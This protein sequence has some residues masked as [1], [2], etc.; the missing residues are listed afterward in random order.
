[1]SN[2]RF[3]SY[4][5]RE[6]NL[7]ALVKDDAET[8]YA[9]ELVR[10]YAAQEASVTVSVSEVELRGDDGLVSVDSNVSG[11]EWS[12]SNAVLSFEQLKTILGGTITEVMGDEGVVIGQRY[13]IEGAQN[14]PY[15]SIIAKTE[16]EGTLK[17]ILPKC[18][19]TGG[20]EFSFSDEEYCVLSAS[21]KSVRRESDG[22]LMELVKYDETNPIS[23]EDLK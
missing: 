13:T 1:M 19:A 9:D 23:I 10:A 4:G 7:A 8:I 21:G 2:K 6:I 18:K 22:K 16:K 3:T 20:L 17:I 5:I 11:C 14:L 15:F 12:F